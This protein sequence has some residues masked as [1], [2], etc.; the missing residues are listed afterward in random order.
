MGGVISTF[1]ST[2]TIR[3]ILSYVGGEA[4]YIWGLK[5]NLDELR[6]QKENLIAKKEGMLNKVKLAEQQQQQPR[7]RW[8]FDKL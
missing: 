2:D 6:T 4:K 3:S 8:N 1:L 5:D 7:G